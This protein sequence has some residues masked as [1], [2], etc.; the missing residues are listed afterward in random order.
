MCI[1]GAYNNTKY[2]AG[3]LLILLNRRKKEGKEGGR[4][5]ESGGQGK[6]TKREGRK[7]TWSN[8]TLRLLHKKVIGNKQII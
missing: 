4:R 2:L 6:G 8:G 7:K 1:F 5:G 3:R